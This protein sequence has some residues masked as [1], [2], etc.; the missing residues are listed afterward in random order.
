M[1]YLNSP[2]FV[3]VVA[4]IDRTMKV[5]GIGSQRAGEAE[6]HAGQD[7]TWLTTLTAE[8]RSKAW[9]GVKGL[10]ISLISSFS[11]L[12]NQEIKRERG[13]EWARERGRERERVTDLICTALHTGT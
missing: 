1:V 3:V 13:R 4:F 7:Q 12:N 8:I 6:D 11:S 5:D 9:A 10:S 2:H